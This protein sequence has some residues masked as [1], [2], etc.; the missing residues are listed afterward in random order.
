MITDRE[1]DD[2]ARAMTGGEPSGALRAR[3]MQQLEPRVARRARAGTFATAAKVLG[4]AAAVAAGVIFLNRQPA[5]VTPASAP[6][7]VV[8]STPAR[9]ADPAAFSTLM[10]ASTASSRPAH[11]Q[12]SEEE[13]AWQSRRLP[14]LAPP[15]P[16]ALDPI[17][18]EPMSIAPISVD[19]I[20]MD[21]LVA[22][23]VGT[24]TAGGPG[25]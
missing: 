15:D 3:V 7:G 14:A 2:I 16:L 13:R 22:P 5:E 24:R 4:G 18:P 20:V 11:I 21:P 9:P 10:P 1:I 12:M 25:S 6:A 8:A 23:S 19:P 17:Q